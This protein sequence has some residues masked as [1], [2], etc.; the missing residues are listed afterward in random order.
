MAAIGSIIKIR[1]KIIFCGITVE[2]PYIM[3]FSVRKMRGQMSGEFSASL[4]IPVD[5]ALADC[6]GSEVEIFVGEGYPSNQIFTGYVRK[7]DIRPSREDASFFIANIA[8][9]D[10]LSV[11]EGQ[12]FSRRVSAHKMA[13]FGAITNVVRENESFKERFPARIYSPENRLTDHPIL[14]G[15]GQITY[16][17]PSPFST[18]EPGGVSGPNQISVENVTGAA[19]P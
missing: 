4:R 11:L 9:R 2:T 5:T 13:R 8:G 12:T 18:V 17:P 1:A 14:D 7:M 16:A 19:G 15:R 3:S 10:V 6:I